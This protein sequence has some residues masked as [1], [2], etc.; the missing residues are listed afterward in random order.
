MRIASLDGRAVLL[1]Q[2]ANR[3]PGRDLALDIAEASVDIFGPT[4]GDVFARWTEFTAWAAD[5]DV[6]A[7]Q[8][9][10][11]YDP[12]E[13]GPPSPTP[14]QV[15]AVGLNYLDHATE[16]DHAVPEHP[17]VFTKFPSS[18]VGPVAVVQLS[19]DRV[20]WEA[21]LVV[22]IGTGG[23]DISEAGAWDAVAGLT[24][25]QDLSDRTVQQWG[26]PAAQF[27]LGKSFAGY[28][29][30]GPAVVTID[31]VRRFVDPDAL[32]ITCEVT[33]PDGETRTLQDGSTRDLIFGV[34]TLIARLSAV[35]ELRP[36]DLVFTGTPSGVGVGRTPPMFLKDGQRLVSTI[37]AVGRIAQE[38]RT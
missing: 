26:A 37:Q 18:L 4:P 10:H 25:G 7:D 3:N 34:P 35:V 14:S 6:D 29:P 17:L 19:G 22:V 8:R 24:V 9:S 30:T 28:S 12:A 5:V 36:G 15:F 16:T 20:D 1:G 33:D 32:R 2:N 23:R 13:L 38:L 11:P 31:E 27:A 21:E